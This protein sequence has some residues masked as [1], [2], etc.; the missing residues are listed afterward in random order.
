MRSFLQ[1]LVR[2]AVIKL[3][4]SV[5]SGDANDV[6]EFL[7]GQ[8]A[9]AAKAA[10]SGSQA[11]G[12]R[13]VNLMMTPQSAASVKKWAALNNNADTQAHAAFASVAEDVPKKLGLLKGD[14]PFSDSALDAL[15]DLTLGD[16]VWTMAD[17]IYERIPVAV[18]SLATAVVLKFAEHDA[19]TPDAR[20]VR[21]AAVP[22]YC[23]FLCVTESAESV[24]WMCK[25]AFH[26]CVH[27][28]V[29]D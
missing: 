19:L 23:S 28:R 25:H 29:C 15:R 22:A 16:L 27:E 10:S 7:A 5:P 18:P 8:L 17:A 21:G 20:E 3:K 12:A 4:S 13:S 14:T 1:D 11:P 24:A 6:A 9:S 2:K 26:V